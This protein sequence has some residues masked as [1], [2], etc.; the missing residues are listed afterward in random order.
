MV[1]I[2][3]VELV[4]PD[5]RQYL[6]NLLLNKSLDAHLATLLWQGEHA[7][8]GVAESAIELTLLGSL[9]HV[10]QEVDLEE[11]LAIL[12]VLGEPIGQ[13]QEV[14]LDL[15]EVKQMAERA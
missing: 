7:G 9:W 11:L 15:V 10:F 3:C 2:N 13:H 14:Q 8:Q 1:L 4:V 6:V 12:Y 5:Q